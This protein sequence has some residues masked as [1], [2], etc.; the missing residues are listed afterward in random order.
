MKVYFYLIISIGIML[1]FML[2]GIDG[3]GSNV[4]NLFVDSNNTII[5]PDTQ[6]NLNVTD[7][8]WD[9]YLNSNSYTF[10]Q[11]ILVAIL[12]ITALALLS[13]IQFAGFSLGQDK[14]QAVIAGIAYVIFGFIASDMWS[15]VSLM[16]TL[17]VDW[18][19]W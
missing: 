19:S 8:N 18:A 17:G 10:F 6:T 15:I 3:V 13:G 12:A 2:A 16:F 4:R 11:K 9:D 7:T 14:T 5:A 1:T